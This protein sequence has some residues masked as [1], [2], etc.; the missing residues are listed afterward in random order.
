MRGN[1]NLGRVRL[2]FFF[3]PFLTDRF[4]S[5]FVCFVCVRLCTEK[6]ACSEFGKY[7]DW[8]DDLEATRKRAPWGE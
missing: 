6:H 3:P 1:K 5:C 7:M 2:L 4:I 8:D